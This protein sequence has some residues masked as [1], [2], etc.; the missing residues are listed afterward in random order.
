MVSR[1]CDNSSDL[2][3]PTLTILHERFHYGLSQ[4][5]PLC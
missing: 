5:V 3:R 4:V 1:E 2:M